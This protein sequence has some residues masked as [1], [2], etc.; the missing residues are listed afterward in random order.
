MN[1]Q[2][3]IGPTLIAIVVFSIHAISFSNL[4][5]SQELAALINEWQA[6]HPICTYTLEDQIDDDDFSEIVSDNGVAITFVPNPNTTKG[7]IATTIVAPVLNL[8]GGLRKL[9]PLM[10]AN[11]SRFDNMMAGRGLKR[12]ALPE[13]LSVRIQ[14]VHAYAD[15]DGSVFFESRIEF[16]RGRALIKSGDFEL[17]KYS[18]KG[19]QLLNVPSLWSEGG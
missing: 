13:N 19:F 16:V 8:P 10:Q 14:I 11:Q 12:E 4:A 5:H 17:W 9:R 15:S 3:N 7:E 18:D 6:F 1:S 2:H